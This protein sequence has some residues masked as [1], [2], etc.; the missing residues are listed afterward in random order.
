MKRRSMEEK[1]KQN[2]RIRRLTNRLMRY[3]LVL[4]VCCKICIRHIGKAFFGKR[5]RYMA[6][7]M[8]G[9]V[10]VYVLIPSFPA[11]G[12]IENQ[13]TISQ[14]DE[15]VYV[16]EGDSVSENGNVSSNDSD[17]QLEDTVSEEDYIG[18]EDGSVSGNIADSIPPIIFEENPTETEQ[19]EV[20]EN[21]QAENLEFALDDFMEADEDGIIRVEVPTSGM[22]LVDPYNI[23]RK[24]QITSA[25]FSIVNHCSFDLDVELSYVEY[26]LNV[27]NSMEGKEKD[28][29]LYLRAD[30]RYIQLVPGISEGL[31]RFQL[32]KGNGRTY[33]FTGELSELSEGLWRSG[34]IKVSIVYQFR[35]L[36][37]QE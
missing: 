12:N 32:E 1:G 18:L 35:R 4:V 31:E 20:V 10:M 16:S 13:L 37:T 30:D 9:S 33:Q 29:Q 23:L 6:M 34:D 26:T 28:C 25:E 5:F 19:E 27:D 17:T 14:G 7:F 8:T 21:S 3:G 15:V 2:R 11:M 36:E 24:G 22:I